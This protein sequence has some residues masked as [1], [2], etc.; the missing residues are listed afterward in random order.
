VNLTEMRTRVRRDLHD[1]DSGSYRW[2]DDELD[3]HIQHALR[4][5]SEQVP[6]EQKA[7]QATTAESRDIDISGLTDRI[8]VEA[9]EFPVDDYP[10][11]YQRYS[12]WGDILT[13]ISGDEPDGSDCHIYYG[14]LHTLDESGSTISSKHEDLVATGA[15]AYAALEW[16]EY[17]INK[18][19]VGGTG[20]A[21]E[22]RQWG[23]E[24]LAFFQEEVQRLGRRQRVRVQRLFTAE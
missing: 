16:A 3:R 24:R 21:R 11:S 18:V 20:V 10:A 22:Y 7:I 9:V 19:N 4:E 14:K 1:E 8:M 6:Y 5:F 12:I 17:A 13:I 2:T 23:S 15:A